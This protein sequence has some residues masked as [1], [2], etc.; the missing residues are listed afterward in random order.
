MTAASERAFEMR[1]VDICRREGDLL[2]EDWVFIDHLHVP[3]RLGLDAR[4]RMRAG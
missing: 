3:H 2:A 4:G 1:I